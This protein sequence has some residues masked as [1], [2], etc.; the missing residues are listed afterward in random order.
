MRQLAPDELVCNIRSRFP[1]PCTELSEID[2]VLGGETMLYRG[3]IDLYNWLKPALIVVIP[4]GPSDMISDDL[5]VVMMLWGV[6]RCEIAKGLDACT[7]T[8]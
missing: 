6:G 8:V 2:L 5:T 1:T 3:I 7:K 4:T